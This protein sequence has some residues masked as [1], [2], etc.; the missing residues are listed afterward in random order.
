MSAPEGPFKLYNVTVAFTISFQQEI[1]VAAHNEEEAKAMAPAQ[2]CTHEWEHFWD[3]M[4]IT[5]INIAS[6]REVKHEH[7]DE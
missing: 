5:G 4:Q 2:T 7:S 6:V 3:N 1:P